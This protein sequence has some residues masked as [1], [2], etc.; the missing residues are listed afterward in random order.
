MHRLRPYRRHHFQLESTSF[1]LRL[2]VLRYAIQKSCD[3]TLSL[4]FI[5]ASKEIQHQPTKTRGAIAGCYTGR[6]GAFFVSL[7]SLVHPFFISIK[8]I[9]SIEKLIRF[10][11]HQRLDLRAS[12]VDLIFSFSERGPLLFALAP[13]HSRAHRLCYHSD[14]QILSRPHTRGARLSS[15]QHLCAT[16]AILASTLSLSPRVCAVFLQ[17]EFAIP[18]A[19]RSRGEYDSREQYLEL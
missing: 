10:G 13:P 18:L 9:A 7:P 15:H 14:I 4:L 2:N 5:G 17:R 8:E 6:P 19:K 3:T 16:S 11:S 12:I 1:C